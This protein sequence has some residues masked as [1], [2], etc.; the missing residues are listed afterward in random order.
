MAF[1]PVAGPVFGI[2]GRKKTFFDTTV[3]NV[4]GRADVTTEADRQIKVI[5]YPSEIEEIKLIPEGIRIDGAQT[6]ISRE[7]L[8]IQSQ[9][10]NRQTYWRHK[11]GRVYRAVSVKEYDLSEFFVYI[12]ALH[13]DRDA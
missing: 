10:S 5:N 7:E 8:Y 6:I 4:G 1:P 11:S 13:D 3:A 2:Y 9:N 12:F